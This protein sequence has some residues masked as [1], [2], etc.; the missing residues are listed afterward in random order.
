VQNRAAAWLTALATAGAV[1]SLAAARG[2]YYPEDWSLPLLGATL[3]AAAAL[4]RSP[5]VE[6]G[7]RGLLLAGCLWALAAWAALSAVWA[8]SAE[9]AVLEAERITIYAAVALLLAL[10]LRCALV[11]PLLAGIAAGATVVAVYALGTRLLPGRLGGAYDPSG[12]YQLGD[13]IG[14]WNA[15]GILVVLGALPALG[16][17]LRGPVVLRA[18]AGAALVPLAATL[19]F[20]FSRGALLAGAAAC[21]VLLALERRRTTAL[22]GTALLAAAPLAGVLAARRLDALTAPGA[23]LQTAQEQG[24]RLAWQLVLLAAAGALAGLATAAVDRRLRAEPVLR[25]PRPALVALGVLVAAGLVLAGS[26]LGGRALAAFDGDTSAGG[27]LNARLVSAAGNGRADYW[28]VAA[29][30][31]LD[32]PVLGAGAGGFERTWL[33]ARD[34]PVEA[35]DAHSLYLE[36]PAELGPVGLALLAAALAVPLAALRRRGDHPLLPAAAA[37]YAAFLLHAA[38]DWDWELPVVALP[39]LGCG[40]AVVA[41]AGTTARLR[42]GARARTAAA[43][44]LVAAAVATV[45]LHVGN[46][47]LSA[48]EA[49]LVRDDPAAAVRQARRAAAWLPWS[50]SA[51]RLLG[52][53]ALAQ[54]LDRDARRHLRRAIRLDHGDWRTWFDLA[55]V[56]E[57]HERDKALR[58][59][60]RLNPL[61]PEIAELRDALTTDS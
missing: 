28:R 27:D 51:R 31:T 2:G 55:V 8:P 15:L 21:F 58:T 7:R 19:Y 54:G 6:L 47:A 35:R 5:V 40:L 53:V 39:A 17:G 20:T 36:A 57:G 33:R 52:E 60:S 32:A 38:L 13:P 3:A 22:V 16:I 61:A 43:S 9:G 41:A 45:V 49:A 12:G 11:L 14:Y 48:A 26:A 34:E 18:A 50:A 29:R 56:T 46:R 42:L 23:T 4:V 30:M 59:A 1:A 37:G 25:L 24:H 44:A 10:R